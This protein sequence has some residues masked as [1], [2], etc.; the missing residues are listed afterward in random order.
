[1]QSSGSPPLHYSSKANYGRAAIWLQGVQK[2]SPFFGLDGPSM[3]N[4]GGIH[5]FYGASDAGSA[6]VTVKKVWRFKPVDR[7]GTAPVALHNKTAL[8]DQDLFIDNVSSMTP[9]TASIS[10]SA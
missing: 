1:M 6:D 7:W 10:P 2:K 8:I 3:P 5:I 4:P 9:A